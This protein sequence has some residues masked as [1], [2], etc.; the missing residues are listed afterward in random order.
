[1]SEEQLD[2]KKTIAAY[3]GILYRAVG[4]WKV[5]LVVFL[6][7]TTAGTVYAATRRKIYTSNTRIR[8]VSARVSGIPEGEAMDQMHQDL[9]S[10]LKQYTQSRRFLQE[11]VDELGLYRDI[12]TRKNM[13]DDEVLDYMRGKLY[14]GVY[15]GDEFGFHFIDYDPDVA[16][17]V[18]K[19]LAE[20][21]VQQRKVADYS[22]FRTKVGRVEKQIDELE[23]RLEGAEGRI[24]RFK[25]ANAD[26]IKQMRREQLGGSMTPEGTTD[27]V[28]GSSDT[29][30][31][32]DD[33]PALRRLRIR[34]RALEESAG[35]IRSKQGDT[36][37]AR[38]SQIGEQRAAAQRE[39]QEAQQ[40]YARLRG[41]YTEEFPDVRAAKARVVE[42]QRRYQE[43]DGRWREFQA[44]ARQP[45]AELAAV[46]REIESTRDEVQALSRRE[47]IERSTKRAPEKAAPTVVPEPEPAGTAG[48]GGADVDRPL[49]TVQE[50]ESTLKRLETEISPLREQYQKLQAQKLELEFQAQQREE[51]GMQYIVIDPA[52]RPSKPSG[53]NRTLIAAATGA[54]GLALGLGVMLLLGFVDNRIYR[55]EDVDRV[56][57]VALLATVPDFE[58]LVA[59]LSAIRDEG[60]AFQSQGQGR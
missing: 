55:A 21:F 19:T 51:G 9:E 48:A 58:D 10:R 25:E 32:Q 8:V 22:V 30:V 53:P 35:Q 3:L 20:N 36:T 46:M 52:N 39:L 7:V 4:F 18:C 31:R 59:D 24:T 17:A 41:Q 38:D 23:E 5:G 40:R 34:L 42:L 11:I 6:V 16:Q 13:T 1:M 14:W 47:A 26:L 60:P 37:S 45:S 56:E 49:K 15:E 12:K 29:H 44:T 54:G 50:V 28:V 27:V 33:S 57:N 43:I 2:L